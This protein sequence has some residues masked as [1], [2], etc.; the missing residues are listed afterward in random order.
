MQQ[1]GSV[2]TTLVAALCTE[3][4]ELVA[5]ARPRLIGRTFRDLSKARVS[6]TVD[7][8]HTPRVDL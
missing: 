3:R 2:H 4:R 7:Y 5:C 6:L 1:G 8:P